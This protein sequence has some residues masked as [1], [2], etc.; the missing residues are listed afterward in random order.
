MANEEKVIKNKQ[1][2]PTKPLTRPITVDDTDPINYDY[3]VKT[4]QDIRNGK[5]IYLLPKSKKGFIQGSELKAWGLDPDDLM[6]KGSA[7]KSLMKL[8]EKIL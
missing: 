7:D 3:V 4:Q 1:K 2:W 6:I 8:M 5:G